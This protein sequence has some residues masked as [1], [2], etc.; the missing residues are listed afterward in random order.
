[1]YGWI[2]SLPVYGWSDG[3]GLAVRLCRADLFCWSLIVILPQKSL[4]DNPLSVY[5]HFASPV[6][7]PKNLIV[8]A[9]T[10]REACLHDTEADSRF[11]FRNVDAG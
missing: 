8:F 1:M 11:F 2:E 7:G 9:S 3:R 6:Q 5:R 10:R 4:G